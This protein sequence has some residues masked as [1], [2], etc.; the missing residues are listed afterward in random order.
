MTNELKLINKNFSF[1]GK[2]SGWR[3]KPFLFSMITLNSTAFW[4]WGRSVSTG[5]ETCR[6]ARGGW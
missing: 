2:A 3:W 6:T 5:Y 4:K 1:L